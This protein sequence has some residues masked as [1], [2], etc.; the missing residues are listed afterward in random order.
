MSKP[1]HSQRGQQQP[2]LQTQQL[3]HQ[4]W[5]GPL[6]PPAALEKFNLIIPGSADRIL[7]M[8]EKE[9]VHR[10]GYEKTGLDATVA[11]S[12]RGQFLG[13]AISAIAILGA[14]YAAYVGANWI[15]SIALVGVPVLG[16]VRAIIRPRSNQ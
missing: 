4:Q 6:P 15:V 13:A 3:L 9:Q 1:P 11:E 7:A 5:S 16:L 14:V 12:K 8:A 2:Q 10:I